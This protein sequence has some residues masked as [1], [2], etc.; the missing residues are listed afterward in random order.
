MPVPPALLTQFHRVTR[1][2]EEHRDSGE[3]ARAACSTS[4]GWFASKAASAKSSSAAVRTV[5]PL[6][7]QHTT[8]HRGD[9]GIIID[10]ENVTFG[11]CHRTS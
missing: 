7:P 11:H 1:C 2:H 4:F 10:N 8:D 3:A 6:V 5:Y 9:I